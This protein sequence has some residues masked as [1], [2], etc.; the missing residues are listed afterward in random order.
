M[1]STLSPLFNL[2]TSAYFQLE[3][4]FKRVT[5]HS[6]FSNINPFFNIRQFQKHEHFCPFLVFMNEEPAE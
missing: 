1:L 6:A 2:T 4:P 5:R 3:T